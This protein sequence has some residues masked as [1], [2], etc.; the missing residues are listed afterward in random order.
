MERDN[1]Q[2]EAGDGNEFDIVS[3]P[4]ACTLLRC[5]RNTLYNLIHAGEIPA[6]RL[7]KVGNWKMRRSQLEAWLADREAESAR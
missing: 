5:H 4:E 3:V 1:N 2:S 6:F 7:G